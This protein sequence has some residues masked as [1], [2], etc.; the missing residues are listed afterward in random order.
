MT[1][2]LFVHGTGV[3]GVADSTTIDTITARAAEWLPDAR[4]RS[5][6]WGEAFGATI[7]PHMAKLLRVPAPDG[8][9]PGPVDPRDAELRLWAVLM[10]HPEE[11]LRGYAAARRAD[12]G[13]GGHVV[14]AGLPRKFANRVRDLDVVSVVADAGVTWAGVYAD[15]ADIVLGS[16]EFS[17][18]APAL[19]ADGDHDVIA[20]AVVA[21]FGHELARRERVVDPLTAEQRDHLFRAVRDACGGVT[22]GATRGMVSGVLK[23]V[24]MYASWPFQSMV[25][26]GT[27]GGSVPA[28]GDILHYQAHGAVVR[29]YLAERV[30]EIEEGPVLLLAHS[31]GGIAAFEMLAERHD[32]AHGLRA[33]LGRVVGLVTAGSQ[34][35]YF[36]AVNAL[37]TGPVLPAR[38]AVPWVNLWNPRDWLSFEAAPVLGRE[39]VRDVEVGAFQPFP[40]AH[41]AYWTREVLYREMAAMLGDAW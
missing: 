27:L 8:V 14:A 26:G 7:T 20:R 33:P 40:A 6:D 2:V 24:L 17:V 15:A 16:E 13:G 28:V 18:A 31:L 3:R 41:G 23:D 21:R 34:I 1:T 10:E 37:A 32:G 22:A 39:R 36:G 25:R 11:E 4:V 5:V 12:A 19:T 38:F 29:R 9:A 35:G 30:A